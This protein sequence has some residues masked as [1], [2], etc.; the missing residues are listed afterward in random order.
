MVGDEFIH[1]KFNAYIFE[2]F[3]TD[4]EHVDV[5]TIIHPQTP[6]SLICMRINLQ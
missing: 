3:I 6:N 2:K 1:P 5:D 4:K